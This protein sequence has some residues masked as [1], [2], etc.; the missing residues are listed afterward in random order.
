MATPYFLYLLQVYTSLI[1]GEPP[2]LSR[3]CLTLRKQQKKMCDGGAGLKDV[4]C[5]DGNLCNAAASGNTVKFLTV[6]LIS[7]SA[8]ATIFNVFY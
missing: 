2:Y 1:S 3:G 7:V 6:G 8:L 4:K 5:C